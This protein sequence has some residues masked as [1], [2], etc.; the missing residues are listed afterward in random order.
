MPSVAEIISRGRY[1]PGVELSVESM[2][3]DEAKKAWMRMIPA[4][5]EQY[6]RM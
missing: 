1:H 5:Y 4:F 2:P 6:G 3:L